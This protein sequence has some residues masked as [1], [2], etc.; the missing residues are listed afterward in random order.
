MCCYVGLYEVVYLIVSFVTHGE[1]CG[2]IG[3]PP[4]TLIHNQF[5]TIIITVDGFEAVSEEAAAAAVSEE[6]VST[7]RAEPIFIGDAF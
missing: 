5:I 7:D 3:T 1:S 4:Q 6:A 2:F